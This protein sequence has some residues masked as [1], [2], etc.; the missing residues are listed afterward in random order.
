VFIATYRFRILVMPNPQK[1][2]T[3]PRLACK[4]S[5]N[6]FLLCAT[7]SFF[8]A[9]SCKVSVYKKKGKDKTNN[10]TLFFCNSFFCVTCVDTHEKLFFVSKK[11]FFVQLYATCFAVSTAHI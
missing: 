8:N 11:V 9:F 10:K 5:K 1:K 4:H 6:L 2:W 7:N 3:L